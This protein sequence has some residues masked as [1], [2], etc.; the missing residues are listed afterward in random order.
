VIAVVGGLP[1]FASQ[2]AMLLR[3]TERK[4]NKK[5]RRQAARAAYQSLIEQALIEAAG[6][7]AGEQVSDEEVQEAVERWVPSY[8]ASREQAAGW[9]MSGAEYDRAIRIALLEQRLLTRYIYHHPSSGTDG[10]STKRARKRWLRQLART[11]RVERR[12]SL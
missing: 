9:G 2:L 7:R 11:I 5:L 12:L 3:G 8:W 6:A 4:A 10:A 1:I